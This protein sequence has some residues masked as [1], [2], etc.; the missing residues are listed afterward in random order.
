MMR[1]VAGIDPE[2]RERVFA[3]QREYAAIPGVLDVTVPIALERSELLPYSHAL[4]VRCADRTAL[5]RYATH[6][7]HT[8]SQRVIHPLVEDF[9]IL[10]GE[11][12]TRDFGFL[13]GLRARLR[14]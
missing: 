3:L 12:T 11:A 2:E 10:E 4:L 14:L 6:P 1:F 13:S 8:A 5:D 9:L 7:V